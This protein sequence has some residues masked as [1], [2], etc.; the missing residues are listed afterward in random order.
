[1]FILKVG[2]FSKTFD[3]NF[4]INA[5]YLNWKLI[6]NENK[7]MGITTKCEDLAER[8]IRFEKGS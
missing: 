6:E 1:M 2:Y 4:G 8:L 7:L 5:T 3:Y